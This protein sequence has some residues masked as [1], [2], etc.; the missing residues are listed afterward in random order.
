MRLR[1]G[2]TAAAGTAGDVRVV[3][4][5]ASWCLEYPD[6]ALI[7]QVPAMRAALA[8]EGVTAL[9]A[10]LDELETMPLGD[11]QRRYVDVFD[12]SRKHA[13]YLSY[14]TDG[15]TRRRGEVL[16]GFKRRYRDSG[17][18]VDTRGELPDYLP[19]A[20][21]FAAI[22]DP[23]AGEA[24]LR[25]Y[26]PSLELLR[27]GLAEDE[28]VYADVVAA[29]CATLPGPSPADR[30]AVQAMVDGPPSESVGL[31]PYLGH[32]DPRLLP[33]AAMDGGGR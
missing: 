12:L 18:L 15:D 21:E 4:Q 32:D 7:A 17:Y 5:A 30:A 25:E 22:A 20:L 14:W 23:Q 8:A 1:R 33:M 28:A 29:V 9:D 31:E 6:E 2:G 10:F 16:A 3:R 24:L 26:R 11:L 13:L 19:L 27:I